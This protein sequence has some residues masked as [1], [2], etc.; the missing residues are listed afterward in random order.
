MKN[1]ELFL[2]QCEEKSEIYQMFVS[3]QSLF[4]QDMTD[5]LM[6]DENTMKQTIFFPFKSLSSSIHI[7]TKFNQKW[8]ILKY[9]CAFNEHL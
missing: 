3:T 2:D 7:F 4:Q 6:T 5:I 8:I 1:I 9:L